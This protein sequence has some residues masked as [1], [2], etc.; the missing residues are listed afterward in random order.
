MAKL[1]LGEN[2]IIDSEIIQNHIGDK[3]IHV[4]D[5][6]TEDLILTSSSDGPTWKSFDD[7]SQDL[8]EQVNTIEENLGN[9]DVEETVF[10][11]LQSSTDIIVNKPESAAELN[12]QPISLTISDI[13]KRYAI[14]GLWKQF[15]G[16]YGSVT[17]TGY[18]LGTETLTTDEA[19]AVLKYMMQLGITADYD[20]KLFNA[21]IPAIL[22]TVPGDKEVSFIAGAA[23]SSL[24]YITFKR[25]DKEDSKDTEIKFSSMNTAFGKCTN[26][27]TIDGIISFNLNTDIN[28]AFAAC[29][30]LVN[31]KIKGL[32]SD[33]N[34]AECE[35]L[36]LESIDYIVSNSNKGSKMTI[37][38]HPNVYGQLSNE[39]IQEY[40]NTYG[41]TIQS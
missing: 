20:S 3:Q 41:V 19:L 10:N 22:I 33:L 9:I 40:K 8:Q 31:L 14:N 27:V 5:N 28:S 7:L 4:P 32:Q 24:K 17:P 6:K 12:E 13:A 15:V 23:G 1:Y 30:S 16:S 37:Y 2:L 34:L 26:L 39:K 36:S 25:T 29:R 11:S 38:I 35:A 18:E 21:N